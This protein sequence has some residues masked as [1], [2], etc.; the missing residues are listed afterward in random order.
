MIIYKGII[1]EAIHCQ[2]ADFQAVGAAV[3]EAAEAVLPVGVLEAGGIEAVF[4]A[5]DYPAEEGAGA[6]SQAEGFP[7][8]AEVSEAE[9]FAMAAEAHPFFRM[10]ADSAGITEAVAALAVCPGLLLL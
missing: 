8:A 9:D 3:P 6:D 2:E 1:E 10:G 4:P 5:E 7:L